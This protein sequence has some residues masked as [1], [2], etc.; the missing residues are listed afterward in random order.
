VRILVFSVEQASVP[1]ATLI[2]KASE[3]KVRADISTVIS[4]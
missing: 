2:E 1:V 4:R 3:Y